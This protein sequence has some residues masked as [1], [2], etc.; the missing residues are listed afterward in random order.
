MHV[1]IIHMGPV[2]EFITAARK[3]R[4]LWFGSW[5]LSELAKA[6]AAG[7]VDA[8]GGGHGLETLVFPFVDKRPALDPDTE[9][10]VPNKIVARVDGDEIRVRMIAEQG[11]LRMHARRDELRD[12]AFARVGRG[13]PNRNEHFDVE[14]A[15][16]QLNEVFEY[17]WVAVAAPNDSPDGY[18]KARA[19]AERL[20]AARKNVRTWGQPS[21]ARPNARK[22]SLDGIHDTVLHEDVHRRLQPELRRNAYQVDADE[23][24]CGIGLLK[25]WGTTRSLANG[26]RLDRFFSTPHLAALPLLSGIQE[27]APRWK[28]IEEAWAKL[29]K[30]AGPAVE[31]L[32]IVPGRPH[33]LFGKTDRA[34]LFPQRVADALEERGYSRNSEQTRAALI[35]LEAFLKAT[36]HREPLPYYAI[37]IADGDGIGALI[38]NKSLQEHRAFSQELA[39]FA[40]KSR[41]IVNE[42]DGCLVYCGGDDVLALLPLHRALECA[43]KLSGHFQR[44]VGATLSAGLAIVHYMHPL[45]E[46]LALARE[47]EKKAKNLDGKNALAVAL[48]KRS[49]ETTFARGAWTELPQRLDFLIQLHLDDAIPDKVGHDLAALARLGDQLPEIQRSEMRRILRRKHAKHGTAPLSPEHAHWLENLTID[50][51]TLSQEMMIAAHIAKAKLQATPATAEE[52]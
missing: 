46:A 33:A 22:S 26:E 40:Q 35:A 10:S 30:E 8:I 28:R 44:D 37:L 34:I 38:R 31:E 20:L 18:K 11:R 3:C 6:A 4:D 7:I 25:R 47:A 29:Q 12:R 15:R 42:H 41:V 50:P 14:A 52:E 45:G 2:Q 49:A 5:V 21:V 1:L 51:T 16:Q 36:G 24:L 39:N 13:D 48:D 17:I 9:T 43:C 19:Q 27:G 32:D 23:H